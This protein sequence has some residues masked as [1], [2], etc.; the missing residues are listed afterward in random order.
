MEQHQGHLL[1][2]YVVYKAKNLW[3]SWCIGGKAPGI[4][5]PSLAGLMTGFYSIALP[6]IKKLNG[7][8]IMIGDNL[9]SHINKDVVNACQENEISFICLPPNSTRLT[10]PLDV[11]F[12]RSMKAKWR[13]L[14][15]EWKRHE[16]SRKTS[17]SII[18]KDRFP[19][20]L[21]QLH[22]EMAKTA[23]SNL[24]SGF[25]KAR[26]YP[27][28]KDEILQRLPQKREDASFVSE[29]FIGVLSELRSESCPEPKQKRKRVNVEPG[30]SVSRLD[31]TGRLS[32]EL[33]DDEFHNMIRQNKEDKKRDEIDEEQDE[34]ADNDAELFND[35]NIH[36]EDWVVMNY[37]GSMFPGIV[38]K[39]ES[40]GA[41]VSVMEKNVATGWKWP[42]KMDQIF[43]HYSNILEKLPASSVQ[44]FNSRGIFIITSACLEDQG[45]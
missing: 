21:K 40:D 15:T 5:G 35:S 4:I 25:R 33:S 27:L 19:C 38:K 45:H 16:S 42:W 11:A 26:T 18:P 32:D 37:E 7:K 31:I 22:D 8:K 10:Q 24:K 9:S 30:K 20:Q 12:F 13:T 44:P 2:P 41:E 36:E 39:V 28:N 34:T 6:Y 29:T 23:A 1:P 17:L 3:D 14:L 43:Y